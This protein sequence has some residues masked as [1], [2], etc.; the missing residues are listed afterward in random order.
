MS[1]FASLSGQRLTTVKLGRP[2]YGAWAADVVLADS[3][4]VSGPVSLVIGNM[5]LAGTSYR[6][7]SFAG[8]RSAR[9]VAGAG[10][11]MKSL[12]SRGYQNSGGV[13]LSM[14]IGDAARVVGETVSV[15]TDRSLGEAW[16]VEAKSAQFLLR[17]VAGT[18]WWVDDAGVTHIGPRPSIAITS[19]F[20]VIGWSGKTGLFEIATEDYAA[21][22]PGA[23]FTAP[24]VTGTQTVSFVE[25]EQDNDG[26]SRMHILSSGTS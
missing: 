24:T 11:W 19:D 23:T 1:D 2:F 22:V 8:S 16:T 18:L 20:Q 26:K 5:T 6:T 13:P 21:W 15:A 12:K 9:V 10:G 4:A 14:V 17:Q 25:L 7:A 3:S